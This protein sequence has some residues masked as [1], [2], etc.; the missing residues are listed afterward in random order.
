M[1]QGGLGIRNQGLMN[2]AYMAELGWKMS[3]HQA[4]LV[5]DCIISKYIHFD[6]VT[7][8]RKG[9]VLWRNIG[10][11]W[12]ILNKN[13]S[14]SLGNGQRIE[15]W[16]DNWLSIRP[17]REFIQ[18]PLAHQDINLKV[19]GV[20]PQGNWDL[21]L[22]SIDI[23]SFI[24]QRIQY[25]PR[26]P[27]RK[28]GSSDLRLCVFKGFSIAR[29]YEAQLPTNPEANLSWLW[30]AECEPKIWFFLWLAWLDRIPHK[31]LSFS[32]RPTID[33]ACPRCQ[34]SSEDIEHMLCHCPSS[35]EIWNIPDTL[36]I[37]HLEFHLWFKENLL[38]QDQF[39]GIVWGALFPY[40]CHEIWKDRNVC[41]FNGEK[42]VRYSPH[43]R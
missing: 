17:I 39:R 7:Q 2:K 1:N 26:P 9:S 41:V 12:E 29:A 8:F 30:K 31:S 4:D 43:S 20:A 33:P 40:V 38:C 36:V 24:A 11:G 32:R 5:Q 34:V 37:S 14:W 27:L 3:Q 13:N 35:S 18:G 21:T 16:H 25:T 15:F 10:R 28:G 42:S 22:L 19:A 23:P 6:Y